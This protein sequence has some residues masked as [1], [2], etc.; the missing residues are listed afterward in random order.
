MPVAPGCGSLSHSQHLG[1]RGTRP[2]AVSA[3]GGNGAT[4]PAHPSPVS[5]LTSVLA[6]ETLLYKGLLLLLPL[7]LVLLTLVAVCRLWL[8]PVML[9]ALLYLLL[10][11]GLVAG[12]VLYESGR[13]ISQDLPLFGLVLFLVALYAILSLLLVLLFALVRTER[14]R[15]RADHEKMV[16]TDDEDE[17]DD[18]N[19]PLY[20]NNISP[21]KKN[22]FEEKIK[23]FKFI[24]DD[25][26]YVFRRG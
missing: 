2:C 13:V 15:R 6:G 24:D 10:A 21:Q 5:P 16:K 18:P 14:R 17:I 8:C 1:G 9:L 25:M 12:V 7:L 3:D 19:A 11:V 22:D 23:E 20:K 26:S 4:L